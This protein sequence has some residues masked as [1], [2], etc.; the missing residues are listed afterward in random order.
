MRP[1]VLPTIQAVAAA[2]GVSTATVSRTLNQPDSVREALRKRVE[3]AVTALGYV[4]NAGA[5]SM[6]LRRSGTIG[7]IFPTVDNAIFAKAI[8]ALQRRLS[9]AGQQLLIATCDY[10]ADAEMRQ[11]VNLVARGVDAL[12][13][14]GA[15]QRPELLEFLQ[16][17]GVPCVH[18]MTLSDDPAVTSVGFD[19]AVAMAQAARYLLDL[20]HRRI[21]MLAGVTRDNDRATARVAGARHALQEAGFDLP[22][23]RLVERRYGIAAAREGFRE[24]MAA[25]PAPT[26]ILCGNDVLAFGALFEAQRLG[27][28]VP[29]ALSIVGFDDLE[30]ANQL[31][32]ALTTV[33]VPTEEMWRA[34]ADR[35]LAPL[36]GQTAPRRTEIE[37]SLVVRGSTAPAPRKADRA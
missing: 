26:A 12:A 14:C 4:P 15:G 25:R 28:E 10:D 3:A 7:A 9:E 11:A 24:L 22:A 30:L 13:L 31:Q 8:D 19:N 18:V 1:T 16:H 21:A 27:I 29:K 20:G 6:M 32:P 34:A 36:R 17:R 2:A 23:H 37:V 5:R 35:L 33:R